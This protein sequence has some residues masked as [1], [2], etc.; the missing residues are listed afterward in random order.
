MEHIAEVIAR[1]EPLRVSRRKVIMAGVIEKCRCFEDC[2]MHRVKV[3]T[4]AGR[5]E[6]QTFH[7][8]DAIADTFLLD[9]IPF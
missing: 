7:R 5:I 4:R 2:T 9:E 8:K 6:A 3:S 1:R